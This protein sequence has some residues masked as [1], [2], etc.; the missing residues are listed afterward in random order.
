MRLLATTAAALLLATSASAMDLGMGL[1]L[2]TEVTAEYAVDAENMTLTSTPELGYTLSGFDFM[3]ST[4]LAIY[5]DK[6][7]VED[8]FSTLP[9][10]DFTVER[11]VME[12]MTAYVETSY[13]LDAGERGEITL[14]TT[15]AF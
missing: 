5:N 4:E 11:V 15:F 7:V 6:F 1:S 14:G 12:G 13:D 9:T 10:I 8:T 3:A 2:N